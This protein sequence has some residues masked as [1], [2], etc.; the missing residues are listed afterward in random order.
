MNKRL[1][2]IYQIIGAALNVFAYVAFFSF[3][4]VSFMM[5]LRLMI[6]GPL[7]VAACLVIYTV[8]SRLF[9]HVVVKEQRPMRRS[10]KEWIVANAVVVALG[11]GYAA[12]AFILALSDKAITEAVLGELNRSAAGAGDKSTPQITYNSLV[13]ISVSL[14]IVFLLGVVHSIWT[15]FLVKRYKDSFQ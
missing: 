2:L 4:A 10:H 15:L 8:L 5:G 12:F 7:F 9:M 3:V 14:S 13:A 1:I 6:L 11:L